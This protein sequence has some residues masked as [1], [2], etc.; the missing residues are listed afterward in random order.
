MA[1]KIG[2]VDPKRPD[3]VQ[4]FL[5]NHQS[6]FV[7]RTSE[8]SENV[9]SKNLSADVI[10]TPVVAPAP[11][12]PTTPR[13]KRKAA[14]K[15]K[16]LQR[17]KTRVSKSRKQKAQKDYAHVSSFIDFESK[18]E[19]VLSGVLR[20]AGEIVKKAIREEN[21][22]WNI[23]N[24]YFGKEYRVSLNET[25]PTKLIPGPPRFDHKVNLEPWK[26]GQGNKI[27]ILLPSIYYREV[28][29]LES[30]L[31]DLIESVGNISKKEIVVRPKIL[32]PL[33]RPSWEKQLENAY[34]VI[35]WGSFLCV[36]AMAKGVPTISLGWCPATPVSFKLEDLETEKLQQE[37]KNRLA[38]LDSLTWFS[39]DKEEIGFAY[40]LLHEKLIGEKPT[41][42]T[43]PEVT[44]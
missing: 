11:R 17:K 26:G 22:W 19:I 34:C 25:S 2:Y 20:G 44:I 31:N 9:I 4:L 40:D 29:K 27:I 21:N 30:F 32:S 15:K 10:E 12:I 28:F 5:A 14:L 38:L 16:R 7:F 41:I 36:D 23:D 3:R 8:G 35:S 24:G 42:L 13:E 6:S 33:E 43:P 18:D 39:Y 1:N 37:P